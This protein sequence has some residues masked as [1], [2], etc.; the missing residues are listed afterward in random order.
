M[1]LASFLIRFVTMRYVVISASAAPSSGVTHTAHH[2]VESHSLA[3]PC[4]RPRLEGFP[5]EYG[6]SLDQY[7]KKFEFMVQNSRNR[8]ENHPGPLVVRLAVML[9]LF[10]APVSASC[11]SD[12]LALESNPVMIA[13][14][15]AYY[16]VRGPPTCMR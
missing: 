15:D 4:F 10:A 6:H 1:A 12:A 5:V 11:D 9:L 16:Q 8:R 14:M 7:L 3:A 13:A 2:F